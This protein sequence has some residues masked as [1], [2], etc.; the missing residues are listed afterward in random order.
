M[1]LS[2]C[3][4]SGLVAEHDGTGADV[5]KREYYSARSDVI[6]S[7]VAF[8][9]EASML[10]GRSWLEVFIAPSSTGTAKVW[11]L[12][13]GR[14]LH[15]LAGH[16][17]EVDDVAWSHDGRNLAT[18]GTDGAGKLRDART[19]AELVALTGHTGGLFG[20][21]FHPEGKLVATGGNDRSIRLWEVAFGNPVSGAWFRTFGTRLAAGRDF[22]EGDRRSAPRV[23]IVD[24]TFARRF[25]GTAVAARRLAKRAGTV[26][27]SGIA[28]AEVA[29]PS[30]A[31]C[32]KA[33]STSPGP[34][35]CRANSTIT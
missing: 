13:T 22:T 35:R 21:A 4:P 7:T 33:R 10:R 2:A 12:E 20:N 31:G 29:R 17:S 24:E 1:A 34:R 18:A 8:A 28:V 25:S 19:G 16:K 26:A 14:L 32:A 27:T 30:T 3:Q 6:G 11:E 9:R 5:A 23:A 15:T